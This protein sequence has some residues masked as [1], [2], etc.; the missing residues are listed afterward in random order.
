MR[1][2][3][4]RHVLLLSALLPLVASQDTTSV[5][6]PFLIDFEDCFGDLKRADKNGDGRVK[7]DEYLGFIQTYASKQK[8]IENPSL[9]LQQRI[10][11]TTIACSC[12]AVGPE[13]CCLKENAEILT[14]GATNPD[15]TTD[16]ALYLTSACRITD[17]TLGPPE[18]EEPAEPRG[19]PPALSVFS[20]SPPDDDP[21]DWWWFLIA[22]AL[23]LLLCCCGF[24]VVKRRQ[25]PKE[26]EEEE[27]EAAPVDATAAPRLRPTPPRDVEAPDEGSSAALPKVVLR[28]VPKPADMPDPSEYDEDGRK[29]RGGGPVGEE[30]EDEGRKRYGG[31]RLPP[32]DKESPDFKLRPVPLTDKEE[33][34]DWDHPGR[35]FDYPKDKDDISA[36]EVEHYEPDGGV[37]IPERPKKKP[38][39]YNPTWERGVPVDPDERDTRKHRIQSGLGEGEVWDKLDASESGR[40]SVSGQPGAFD[41]VVQNALGT[42]GENDDIAHDPDFTETR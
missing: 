27:P 36:G 11:F 34:P 19:L 12:L 6:K 41:W 38:V 1:I 15:R 4:T 16:Q 29:R 3:E 18:C 9:K 40:G 31:P 14:A 20:G 28:K 24:A 5:K 26:I 17:E 42:L 32:W 35:P 22:A 2:V 7:V 13:D 39:E 23:L 33:D 21:I 25:Q 30:E 37:H 8:C 10:A